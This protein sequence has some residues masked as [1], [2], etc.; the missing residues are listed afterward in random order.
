MALA[1]EATGLVTLLT[2]SFWLSAPLLHDLSLA[3]N[4]LLTG[5][6]FKAGEARWPS[7]I[8]NWRRSGTMSVPPILSLIS[9]SVAI[10]II[11]FFTLRNAVSAISIPMMS[12][13]LLCLAILPTWSASSRQGPGSGSIKQIETQFTR[14]IRF[15]VIVLPLLAITGLVVATGYPSPTEPAVETLT[16]NNGAHE[17]LTA[18]VICVGL[19]LLMTMAEGTLLPGMQ[20][21]LLHAQSG[22]DRALLRL[23]H[24]LNLAGWSLLAA[25][26][27]LPQN[28][29]SDGHLSLSAFW[30]ILCGALIR[31]AC[32]VALL[33]IWRHV[34]SGQ[35]FWPRIALITVALLAVFSGKIVK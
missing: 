28:V 15:V 12:G 9:S 30:G 3:L 33:T 35:A 14:S 20:E 7:L 22:R 4:R 21:T 34:S 2:C 13:L 23:S 31:V 1:L 24:D 10:A 32:I 17:R 29:L 18:S 27:I 11:P 6:S 16:L 5:R 26:L 19:V 8:R 25:S